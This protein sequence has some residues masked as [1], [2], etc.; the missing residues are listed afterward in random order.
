MCIRDRGV[1]VLKAQNYRT[2]EQNRED[3]LARL[4][5]WIKAA[6]IEQKPRIKTKVSRAAKARR[7]DVKK[8]QGAKKS[9]RKKVEF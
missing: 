5:E 7:V 6:T 1:F 3:A 4:V 8:Q 9:M 2:Q